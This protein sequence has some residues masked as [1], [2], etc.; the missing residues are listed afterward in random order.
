MGLASKI[1]YSLIAL[2]LVMGMMLGIFSYQTAYEQVKTSAGVEL[3]GCANITTGLVNPSDV[4]QLLQGNNA[5]LASMEQRL[6]WTVEH[7]SLFKEVFLLSLDGKILAADQNVKARGYQ[8]GDTFYFDPVAQQMIKEQKHSMYSDV[9]TYDGVELMSGYGP[10]YK[11]NDSNQDIIAVM[12]INFDASI[13]NERTWDTLSTPLMIGAGVLLVTAL[14]IYLLV[15]WM[16]RP[17]TLLTA[18]VDRVTAGD[19]TIKPL[20]WTSKDEV[21]RLA[22]SV[23]TMVAQLRDMITKVND[24]SLQV[25]SSA[26]ELSASSEETSKAS[27]QAVMIIQEM[28]DGAE[29]QLQ[30]LESGSATIQDMATHLSRMTE[31][32]HEA[33]RIARESSSFALAGGQSVAL[34]NQQM[35]AMD[36]RISELSS[37]IQSLTGFSTQI[38][39]ILGVITG[40]AGETHLLALN[41]TIEAQ[42]AG[43]HGRSF[44]VIAQS[45]RQLSERSTASVKQIA[46]IVS[47][48]V[49]QMQLASEMMQ[50]TSGEVAHGTELVRS[51]GEAFVAIEQSARQTETAIA[52]VAGAADHLL[53]RSDHLVQSMNELVEVADTTVDGAQSMS[54]ASQQQL[55]AMQEVDA[56]AALLS[57]LSGK[58]QQL[59]ERFKV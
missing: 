29:R 36:R 55:A 50:T 14:L 28:S 3:V 1:T 21:G 39:S 49:Q 22:R 35:N 17:I 52:E 30:S 26:Q 44:G 43:E 5:G 38:N 15:H 37:I 53:L 27:E 59:I 51:A 41:A 6:N 2:L 57:E 46:D 56:S 12:V 47:V 10:I 16:M 11:N 7:K 18:E 32:A 23:E 45:V 42:H 34:S 48:V 19:L 9:F 58:L 20:P 8:S 31:H 13:L 54:A 33:A 4:E 24:A 40:I 25:G